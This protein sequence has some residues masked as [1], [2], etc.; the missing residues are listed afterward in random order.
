[1]EISV[2]DDM[3][4]VEAHH[5]SETVHAAVEANFPYVKH[6]RVHINPVSEKDHNVAVELPSELRPENYKEI[7]C[8]VMDHKREK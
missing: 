6:W 8:E 2:R 5:I 1:M 4:V 7:P 3:T